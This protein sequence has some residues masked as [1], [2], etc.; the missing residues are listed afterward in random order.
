MSKSK[1][2]ENEKKD[3]YWNI[4]NQ[5]LLNLLKSSSKNGLSSIEANERLSK[6]GHNTIIN[7]YRKTHSSFSLFISQ[8]KNPII[9]IFLFTA[10]LTLILKE[11]ENASII[12]SIVLMSSFLGFWQEKNASNAIDKLLSM[13]KI[14]TT[15]LRNGKTE[16]IPIEDIVPGD[17]VILNSGDK[18]PADCKILESKDLFINES[19]LTGETYPT[20]KLDST[21]LSKDTPLR[22][23][24]NSLFMGTF[25]VSGTAKSL[26]INTG[27]NTELGKISNRLI[28]GQETEFQKGIKRFG[29]FLVELTLILVLSILVINVYFGRS[30]LES[31]L[32]S[33][34][35]AIG[36]TPQLLPAII[37]INLAH[38][39]KRMAK[40]KVIVKRLESIENLGS[41][42]ILCTDKTGTITSG[43]LK[44]HSFLDINGNN[45][46]KVFLFAYLN[47]IFETGFENPI[48]KSIKDYKRVDLASEY[49][50]IDEIP[51]DFVRK[52]LSIA[53]L[54]ND[55]KLPINS[56]TGNKILITKGALLNI[57]D[58]CS[59][60][61]R[62]DGKIENIYNF[63]D[64]IKNTFKEFGENGYRVIGIAYKL[65][66]EDK[67]SLMQSSPSRFQSSISDSNSPRYLINKDDESNMIFLGFILFFDPLKSEIAE[68]LKSIQ[69]LGVSIK[70]ISGDNKYVAKHV[71]QQIEL[72]DPTIMIGEEMHHMSSHSLTQKVKHVDIFAEIEPNQKEQIILALK[73]SGHTVGYMG[74]GI[75]D[76]PALHAADA[77]ISVDTA[78][79]IVKEA[80]DFVLLEKD[81]NV[82]AKGVE[83]GRRTFANT[84]KYIFMATSANFGNM[85][86]MAGASLFL[87]FLPLLP[88]QVLLVNLLTDI[89]EMAIS[90]DNVDKEMVKKPRKW[91]IK[92]IQKFMLYFGLLS[93]LFD[94]ITFIILI[95]L[96]L[97][98][99]Q[100]RTMWFM[101][102]VISAASIVLI[103]RT[104][105]KF[106][107]KRPSK[108]LII[109]TL[110]IIGV[111]I[112]LP[113]T[114][115]GEIFGFVSPQLIYL[116]I[117][118]FI[119][120]AYVFMAEIVKKR[121]YSKYQY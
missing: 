41:M 116:I 88:K 63:K 25:V 104:K 94:Y 53:V 72:T 2:V 73:K 79:D 46:E 21:L 109:F 91:N 71:A 62:T 13:I 22:K 10:I 31:F 27:K 77:S 90:T 19:T 82:L 105:D 75:N 100:F 49:F 28:V 50:K 80:A 42:D 74:D 103:I 4:S 99:E 54:Q 93:T 36:L 24:M 40:E 34:A 33:L 1:A 38:G 81:L 43:E 23:R 102:S 121:F 17:I 39:A 61:E 86:S 113:Y 56:K 108:Y 119:V 44:V 69:K 55:Q 70:I 111:V 9:I 112:L 58:I 37:S 83:E 48:D 120:L 98:I 12:I 11:V 84:L 115:I 85:F 32:F 118:G 57:L 5:V 114:I 95:I 117:I 101:E 96:N 110:A 87:P 78:T 14:K 7:T 76:T 65:L 64:K 45:N 20:E 15:V 67:K 51:Y 30:V 89:P 47:A 16:D 107:K 92:F 29:Y 52:R 26:V 60:V 3:D 18:V 97:S 106:Y 35:L 6:F 8:L 66:N 59:F 68:S